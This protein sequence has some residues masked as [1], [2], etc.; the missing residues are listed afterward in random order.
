MARSRVVKNF[1]D[2]DFPI[3][4][5]TA[6]WR[7]LQRIG[8]S[9]PNSHVS[10]PSSCGLLSILVDIRLETF[11]FRSPIFFFFFPPLK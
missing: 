1:P 7:V 9:P 11:S 2:H 4:I 6:T 3:R 10:P 5:G 8:G